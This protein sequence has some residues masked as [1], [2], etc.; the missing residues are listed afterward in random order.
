MARSK[1]KTRL[2]ILNQPPGEGFWVSPGIFWRLAGSEGQLL[3][4]WTAEPKPSALP[5]FLFLRDD[6]CMVPWKI[7][8]Q[9]ALGKGKFQVGL[10]G[11]ASPALASSFIKKEVW[12]PAN[13]LPNTK[14]KEKTGQDFR[15]FTFVDLNS[16][17]TGKVEDLLP[18]ARNPLWHIVGDKGKLTV[19]VNA[20]FIVR[21]QPRKR[22]LEA[23]LPQG[24]LELFLV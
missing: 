11:V 5:D 23:R 20:G 16:G 2:H 13:T 4:K 21:V 1:A 9:K 22:R 18:D 3:L 7:T 8:H 24:Y 10:K 14:A 17:Y 12:V 6:F 19:P 15:G